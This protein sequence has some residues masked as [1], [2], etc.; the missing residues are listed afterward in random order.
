LENKKNIGLYQE[1]ACPKCGHK[2]RLVITIYQFKS[3]K[4]SIRGYLQN[5]LSQEQYKEYKNLA[6]VDKIIFG[7]GKYI[8]YYGDYPSGKELSLFV[9]FTLQT[10]WRY[11][12][13]YKNLIASTS[14][15]RMANGRFSE[16]R[17]YLTH[18]GQAR[19]GQITYRLSTLQ[20]T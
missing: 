7:I 15:Q 8:E 20:K 9:G 6:T 18:E 10:I 5:L 17:Y 13:K 12:T 14:Q 19:Y 4:K 2:I 1:I 3:A 16:K 11:T